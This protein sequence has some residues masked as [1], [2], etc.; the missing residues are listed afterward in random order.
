VE[1]KACLNG[2]RRPG[3]HPRLPVTP[4]DLAAEAAAAVAAGADALHVHPRDGDGA[5]SLHPDDVGAAVAAIRAAV[6]GVPVGVSTGLWITGG[7]TGTRAGHLTRWRDLPAGRRP[8]FA[9]CN[10]SEPGWADAWE[11]LRA[12]GVAVEAGV[13]SLADLT[14]LHR[15]GRAGTALRVLVELVGVPVGRAEEVAVA[16]LDRLPGVA[17]GVPVLLH[18]EGESTWPVLRLAARRGLPTRIGLEDVLVGPNG[19]AVA[20]NADL[21]RLARGISGG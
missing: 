2:G 14:E 1:L 6:P 17:P 7:D 9:S 3:A 13:W 19:A 21:V 18:G 8:D 15:C 5:E 16:L 11:L 12:A 10:V 20:G 4:A